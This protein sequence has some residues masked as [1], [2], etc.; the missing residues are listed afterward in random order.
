VA[1]AQGIA[2]SPALDLN[3]A[4]CSAGADPGRVTARRLSR[5]ACKV[6]LLS[7][8]LMNLEVGKAKQLA[9][10]SCGASKECV[11]E[12]NQWHLKQREPKIPVMHIATGL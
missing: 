1:F 3:A 9:S 4:V 12:R 8:Q 6:P 5:C 10:P 2:H 7:L 11:E